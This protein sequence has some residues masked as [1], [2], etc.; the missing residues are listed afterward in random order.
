MSHSSGFTR[1]I[2]EKGQKKILIKPPQTK[3]PSEVPHR[4]K[5]KRRSDKPIHL[6]LERHQP[7]R[8]KLSSVPIQVNSVSIPKIQLPV[9]RKFLRFDLSQMQTCLTTIPECRNEERS[10]EEV[11]TQTEWEEMET[12]SEGRQTRDASNSPLF[13]SRA[14]SPIKPLP[15]L[16]AATQLSLQEAAIQ[17]DEPFLS[18]VAPRPEVNHQLEEPRT[19][20]KRP[21]ILFDN[22]ARKDEEE[23]KEPELTRFIRP[24][25][26]F[27]T[28]TSLAELIRKNAEAPS[29][30]LFR[31][32]PSIFSAKEEESSRL[33]LQFGERSSFVKSTPEKIEMEPQRM[34]KVK[35]E[36]EQRWK[37]FSSGTGIFG[38]KTLPQR[39]RRMDIIDEPNAPRNRDWNEERRQEKQEKR[40]FFG[41]TNDKPIWN[42]FLPGNDAPVKEEKREAEALKPASIPTSSAPTRTFDAPPPR[43]TRDT[44]SA[45]PTSSDTDRKT[46]RIRTKLPNFAGP[47]INDK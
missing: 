6:E 29:S 21:T 16:E 5:L 33:S 23:R 30:W 24:Q 37:P 9:G 31:R 14:S 2:F 38:A 46:L 3:K 35:D 8:K 42:P 19:P 32:E 27:S 12:R 43:D 44:L 13:R 26:V 17:T 18:E 15:R 36:P 41:Q 39:D 20:E 4:E 34:Q 10:C 7:K 40:F 1:P 28:G 45:A 11:G 25:I 22:L 47:R